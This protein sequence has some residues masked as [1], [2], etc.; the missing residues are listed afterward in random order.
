M[1]CPECKHPCPGGTFCPNCHNQ[2]P[3]QENFRGQ[4]GHYLRVLSGFSLI[5]LLILVIATGGVLGFRETLRNLYH[6]GGL[7]LLLPVFLVPTLVGI[8]YWFIL[9]EEEVIV[10]DEYIARHSR[11]GDEKVA[12]R[13]VAAF[14]KHPV[15]FRQT[16]LGAIAW[17]SRLFRK[18]QV[19]LKLPKVSYEI[20]TAAKNNGEP[21]SMRLEP[22]TI[23]DMAWLL[24]LISERIG[25]P[26]D[27]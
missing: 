5:V 21:Y 2:V 14:R 12:W 6:S 25:P 9:R 22:G 11:W 20:V 3:E 19:F 13:D 16:R 23:E 15:L 8:Y 7:W 26:Q 10:T 17:L 1:L 24:Q 18:S 4:G 27:I